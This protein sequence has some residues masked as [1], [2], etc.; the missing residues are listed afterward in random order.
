VAELSLTICSPSVFLD[1]TIGLYREFY[2]AIRDEPRRFSIEQ[3]DGDVGSWNGNY[4]KY[5]NDSDS[6]NVD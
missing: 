3:Q 2:S 5:N 6:W 1:G 4:G